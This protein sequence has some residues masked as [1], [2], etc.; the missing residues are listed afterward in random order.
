M[1]VQPDFRQN[2]SFLDRFENDDSSKLREI[3]RVDSAGSSFRDGL[4][5]QT[6][7]LEIPGSILRIAPE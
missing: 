1:P 4:K 6:R 7:N 3:N 2:I 5:D